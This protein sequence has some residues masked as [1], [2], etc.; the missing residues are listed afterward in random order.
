M[1][2]SVSIAAADLVALLQVRHVLVLLARKSASD[3][4]QASGIQRTPQRC[5]GHEA[6]Y[7]SVA[8]GEGMDEHEPMVRWRGGKYGVELAE[9]AVSLLKSSHESRNRPGTHWDML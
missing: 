2:A 1:A 5:V 9:P 3:R 8:V 4:P 7:T 6:C